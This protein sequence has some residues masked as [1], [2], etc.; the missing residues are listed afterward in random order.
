[1]KADFI[2]ILD[3]GRIHAVGDHGHLLATDPI[4]QEIWASQMKGGMGYGA[5]V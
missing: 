3:N 4:Y 1:M 5:A 2:V